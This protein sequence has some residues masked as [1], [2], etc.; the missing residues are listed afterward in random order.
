MLLLTELK[1][2]MMRN[3]CSEIQGV[4]TECSE[5]YVPRVS[6]QIFPVWTEISV[7]KSIIVY[8]HK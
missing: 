3:I 5:V 7:N 4:W 6:E 8:L 1:V 2:H